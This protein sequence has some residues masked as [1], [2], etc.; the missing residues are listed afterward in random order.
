[1]YTCSQ[2]RFWGF[3]SFLPRRIG[4]HLK[5]IFKLILLIGG[6]GISSEIALIWMSLDFNDKQ[7]TL[8]RL[9]TPN[10]YLNQCWSR[11]M[12]TYGA[13]RPQWFNDALKVLRY[14]SSSMMH[15]TFSVR[16]YQR[17]RF[18]PWDPFVLIST[19]VC[20]FGVT[21]SLS[22]LATD[23]RLSKRPRCQLVT[24][25]FSVK[26]LQCSDFYRS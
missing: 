7:P 11:S 15:K 16:F 20:I 26:V 9:T 5:L 25:K 19:H 1:M 3:N 13:T 4:W 22:S 14:I 12:P 21:L 17:G 6:W 23:H 24:T 8:V 10:H 18:Y 2:W